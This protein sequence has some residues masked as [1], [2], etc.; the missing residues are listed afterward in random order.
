MTYANMQTGTDSQANAEVGSLTEAERELRERLTVLAKQFFLKQGYTSST[1]DQVASTAKVSKKTVYRLFRT[2]EEV[3]RSVVHSIMRE[4]EELTD[5][6]FRS[7]DESFF[8][9]F[10]RLVL[11]I[12]PQYAQLRSPESIREMRI[13]APEMYEEF[14][15]WRR[16]RFGLFTAMLAQA[17]DEGKIAPEYNFDEVIAIYAALH[18]S[19]MDYSI[20]EQTEVPPAD[21]Y[22]AFADIFLNGILTRASE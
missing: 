20:R 2:K 15:A 21:A 9:R 6:L 13:V 11:H 4:I 10:E 14:D 3:L 5:P 22:T 7:V 17:R 8:D 16:K 12:S 1:M 18:N 19:C